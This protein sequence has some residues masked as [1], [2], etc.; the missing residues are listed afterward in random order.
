M[1]N[2]YQWKCSE[3]WHRRVVCCIKKMV[4]HS[5]EKERESSGHHAR[6]NLVWCGFELGSLY[7]S[8]ERLDHPITDAWFSILYKYKIMVIISNAAFFS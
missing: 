2:E 3:F 6:E 5:P 8:T 4:N 1:T 7:G